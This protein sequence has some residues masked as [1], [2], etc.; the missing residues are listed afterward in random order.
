MQSRFYLYPSFL[1]WKVLTQDNLYHTN[2][3]LL[4]PV[5]V[6]EDVVHTKIFTVTDLFFLDR[7]AV[8]QRCSEK[9]I[10]L[11][12][13]ENSQEMQPEAWN[14]FKKKAL[15]QVF[16]CE[17]WEISK[18]T[19][20]YRTFRVA[21]SAYM[22]IFLLC[23]V[24]DRSSPSHVFHTEE[25]L[26]AFQKIPRENIWDDVQYLQSSSLQVFVTLCC[27]GFNGNF[28][29]IIK[30]AISENISGRLIRSN[31]KYYITALKQKSDLCKTWTV[32]ETCTQ[33]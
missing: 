3:A 14:F 32:V 6:R 27:R 17:F 24:T 11:E 31:K 12:I 4:F 22:L 1:H 10:C 23:E 16:S 18:N 9:N 5:S 19:F 21:A 2:F 13:S 7:E 30:V 28:S 29:K 15:T 26:C 25:T 8:T 20:P 33:S